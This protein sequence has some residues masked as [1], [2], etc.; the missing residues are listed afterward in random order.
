[1]V[2][3]SSCCK[4]HNNSN[5]IPDVKKADEAALELM[6]QLITLAAGVLVLSV[7][8]TEKFSCEYVLLFVLLGIAWL[9]LIV[10]VLFGLQTI[11]AIVK[12]RLKPEYDWSEG[13]GK[14]SAMVSKYSF[15]IGLALFA[16]FGF[17]TL[18][19]GSEVI[20]GHL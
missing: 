9:A 11:S 1:M 18:V 6:K 2:D 3:P 16:I 5:K 15:V 17:I 20:G 8:F 4:Q 19:F 13:Y 14:K 12:S 10:S 7:T